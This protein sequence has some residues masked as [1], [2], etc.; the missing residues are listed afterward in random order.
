M[1]LPLRY[2]ITEMG[3]LLLFI[4]ITYPMAILLYQQQLN[5]LKRAIT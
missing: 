3:Y 1:D 4:A 5:Q 2:A